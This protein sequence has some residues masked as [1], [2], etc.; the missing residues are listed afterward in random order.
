M[1]RQMILKSK[2]ILKIKIIDAL[3]TKAIALEQVD[4]IPSEPS[5]ICIYS[6]FP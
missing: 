5:S 3:Y 2:K 4:S 6:M 1:L